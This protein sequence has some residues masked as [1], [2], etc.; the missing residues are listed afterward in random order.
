MK[1]AARRWGRLGMLHQAHLLHRETA[2]PL[3]VSRYA[4]ARQAFVSF[5]SEKLPRREFSVRDLPC[6]HDD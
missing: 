1:Q 2:L 5:P 3:P 6:I 4:G